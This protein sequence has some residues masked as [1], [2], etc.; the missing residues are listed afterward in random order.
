MT[1]ASSKP[2]SLRI[3]TYQ[4]GFGDCFLLTFRY[5]TE[6]R[7]V[8]IDF[9]TTGTPD[10]NDKELLAAVAQNIK[11][12]TAG[13]LNAIVLTH[14]HRDHIRGFSTDARDGAAGTIIRSLKPD[15]VTQPWTEDPKA[16]KDATSALAPT[17]DRKKRFSAATRYLC[18]LDAM[19]ILADQM[20]ESS[21]TFLLTGPH[22]ELRFI[23][24]DNLKNLSAVKN[25]QAIGKN[26]R[27]GS[28]YVNYG[29]KSKLGAKVLPG[30][31]VKVLG[32]PT[33]DQHKA[34]ATET[35]KNDEFWMLHQQFWADQ[36]NARS[37]DQRSRRNS[38][39][40]VA[41]DLTNVPIWARWF[42]RKAR[43][44]NA[45]EA[46]SL[47]RILDDAMNN[48]SV[49]LMFT[50][51]SKRF[52]FPGDAQIEN[53]EYALKFAPDKESNLKAFHDVTVLKVG[54]HGSRNATPKTLFREIV[55]DR[56]AGGDKPQFIM[57]TMPGKH[58]HKENHSEV[59]R[60]TLVKE[61]RKA[62][63]LKSTADLPKR[64][65]FFDEDYSLQ[66]RS[67]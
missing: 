9:G 62:G 49:I 14:R 52:L 18:S 4:V 66:T 38:G 10:G 8:L 2:S 27:F 42:V 35:S 37:I 32:P 24:E 43:A 57:S 39:K 41:A 64:I 20:F 65:E 12:A 17:T 11:D 47:V 25:L 3:R 61:L 63:S 60:A 21:N 36:V 40:R 55:R 15:L 44:V 33:I 51:G 5:S 28:E 56:K 16:A 34:V 19:H 6:E 23:G 26:A 22:D 46:L 7:H 67:S 1:S 13:K 59:P 50:I 45:S 54:H 29:S 58:G 48:T 30:V 31:E 53:W